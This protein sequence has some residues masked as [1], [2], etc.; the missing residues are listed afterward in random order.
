MRAGLGLLWRRPT[1]ILYELVVV[2]ATTTTTATIEQF[3]L[4]VEIVVA[5]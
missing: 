2:V 3:G 1:D 5:I 4:T